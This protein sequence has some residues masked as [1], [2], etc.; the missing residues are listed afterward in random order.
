M[1]TLKAFLKDQSGAVAMEYGMIG[2]LIATLVVPAATIM[3]SEIIGMLT[4]VS[5]ALH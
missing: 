4:P 5:T 2:V 3:G 1:K